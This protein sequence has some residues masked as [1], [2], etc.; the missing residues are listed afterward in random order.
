MLSTTDPASR[1]TDGREPAG[2]KYCRSVQ[3]CVP[4][5]ES[6]SAPRGGPCEASRDWPWRT[7]LPGDL[8]ILAVLLT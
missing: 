3:S 2:G 1:V 4:K 8:D 5:S 7:G 6:E